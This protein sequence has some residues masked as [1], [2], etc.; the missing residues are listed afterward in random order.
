MTVFWVL[1]TS[2][3][4]RFGELL[5]QCEGLSTSELTLRI[6]ELAEAKLLTEEFGDY[7]LSKVGRDLFTII[8]PVD[9]WSRTWANSML[10]D[11]GSEQAPP[12]DLVW[13][14]AQAA[15]QAG[16]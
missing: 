6:K 8:Q 5:Q 14:A 11:P 1:G 9:A 12:S 15:A 2:S 16:G 4:K 7:A 13:P 10:A 3:P